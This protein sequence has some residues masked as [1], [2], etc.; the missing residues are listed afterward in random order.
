MNIFKNVELFVLAAQKRS[1]SAAAKELMIPASTVSYRIAQMEKELGQQLFARTTRSVELTASGVVLY[2]HFNNMLNEGQNALEYLKSMS[3]VPAGF[4]Y[5]RMTSSFGIR[6]LGP[7]L[8]K[9]HEMYPKIDLHLEVISRDGTELAGNCELAILGGA[10]P[11]SSLYCRKIAEVKRHLYASPAYL[12]SAGKVNNPDELLLHKCVR[13]KY[14]DLE[15]VWLLERKGKCVEIPIAGPF[16]TNSISLVVQIVSE[17]LGIGPIGDFLARDLVREGV[18][19]AVLPDWSLPPAPIYA[20]TRSKILTARAR[21]F[22][23]FLVSELTA[24][25]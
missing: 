17:G 23:D 9:F 3:E 12:A 2:Q 14:L 25:T 5:V 11:H 7:R 6:L 18:L 21:V 16:T 4:L 15:K 24:L 13:I 22:I 20:L 19:V 10:L 8:G 1:F